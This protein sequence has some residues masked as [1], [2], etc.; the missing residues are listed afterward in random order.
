MQGCVST[1]LQQYHKLKTKCNKIYAATD[2][3]VTCGGKN[4][5]FN[6]TICGNSN[7]LVLVRTST[8]TSTRTIE[9]PRFQ[10]VSPQ[11]LVIYLGHVEK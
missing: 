9:N 11:L 5:T 3:T 4:E 2:V 10:L 7:L 8:R 1:T 6:Q